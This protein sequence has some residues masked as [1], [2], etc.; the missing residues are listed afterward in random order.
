[1]VSASKQIWVIMYEAK[2]CLEA[3][4]LTNPSSLT[5]GWVS[6]YAGIPTLSTLCSISDIADSSFPALS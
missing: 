4:A 1:M 3:S 2:G 5:S 6:G